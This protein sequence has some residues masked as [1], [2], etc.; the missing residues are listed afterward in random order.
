VLHN[1]WCGLLPLHELQGGRE[2]GLPAGR[3]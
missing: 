1:P 3:A 2:E